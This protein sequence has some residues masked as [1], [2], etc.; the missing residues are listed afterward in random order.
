MV[1][2]SFQLASAKCEHSLPL[3]WFHTVKLGSITLLA[4]KVSLKKSKWTP[5]ECPHVCFLGNDVQGACKKPHPILVCEGNCDYLQD[6]SRLMVQRCKIRLNTNKTAND[7]NH[8][9]HAGVPGARRIWVF[10]NSEGLILSPM[11]ELHAVGQADVTAA[12]CPSASIPITGQ[13]S[14][15]Q[16]W[17]QTRTS[18]EFKSKNRYS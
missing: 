13:N 17:N 9:E 14:L 16:H 7:W 10:W 5:E 15:Y 18:S 8:S 6:N 1:V 2:S 4:E 11:P 12:E 3:P